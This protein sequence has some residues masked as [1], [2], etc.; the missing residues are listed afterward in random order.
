MTITS[1]PA[2]QLSDGQAAGT[3]ALQPATSSIATATKHFW[4]LITVRGTFTEAT[5]TATVGADGTISAHLEVDAAS[6]DTKNRK[7]DE[8]LRSGD[9]F[10]A[11]THPA[12]T[13][14]TTDVA[15]TGD[16]TAHVTG[17]LTAGGARHDV[18]FDATITADSGDQA[19]VT[20][21]VVVDHRALG[22]TWSPLGMAKPTTT[23][24]LSLTFARGR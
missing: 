9:F 12:I 4:G 5:G 10:D 19:T 15:I 21:D 7:R 2:Q 1:T 24:H 6:I 20:A 18:A 23:L 22:M 11:E 16:A 14:A 17:T 3:W 13:F 8:H